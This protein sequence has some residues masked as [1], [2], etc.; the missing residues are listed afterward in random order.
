MLMLPKPYGTPAG[1]SVI[2]TGPAEN[3]REIAK[4]CFYFGAP[5]FV[6]HKIESAIR[7]SQRYDCFVMSC[8]AGQFNA[9]RELLG[10][11]GGSIEARET[12]S[13]E[14]KEYLSSRHRG[15]LETTER[16]K[17]GYR[18]SRR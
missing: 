17:E 6:L 5:P 3:A 18:L 15:G 14:Y 7:Y 16:T 12:D 13:Y 1:L 11:F 2:I 4:V 9:V 8:I 10:Q